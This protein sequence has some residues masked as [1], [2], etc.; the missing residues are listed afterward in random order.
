MNKVSI[1]NQIYL[2]KYH[3]VDENICCSTGLKKSEIDVIITKLKENG[4]YEVYR[5]MSDEEY[6]KIIEDEKKKKSKYKSTIVQNSKVKDIKEET[7]QISDLE[8]TFVKVSVKTIMDWS[9]QKGYLDRMLE[10]EDNGNDR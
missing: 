5:K 10:E 8:N 1:E 7:T 3:D 6:E 9:Y 2:C 4:M